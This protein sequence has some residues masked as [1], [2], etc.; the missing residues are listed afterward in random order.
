MAY[1]SLLIIRII[2]LLRGNLTLTQPY[3]FIVSLE[4]DV[5]RTPPQVAPKKSRSKNCWLKPP[6]EIVPSNK[7]VVPEI[8]VPGLAMS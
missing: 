1:V 2:R 3:S 6:V 8:V 4:F 7:R 5:L